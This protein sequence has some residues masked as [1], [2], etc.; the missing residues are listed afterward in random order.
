[1]ARLPLPRRLARWPALAGPWAAA[2]HWAMP[3]AMLA[4]YRWRHSHVASRQ[5]SQRLQ[6]SRLHLAMAW[7][8]HPNARM[9]VESLVLA[10]LPG[11]A[12]PLARGAATREKPRPPQPP[13]C[14]GE[15]LPRV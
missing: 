5:T 1:M 11:V 8:P 14:H 3:W 12:G 10:V 6:A 7:R 15:H 4:S 9:A 13:C 2:G